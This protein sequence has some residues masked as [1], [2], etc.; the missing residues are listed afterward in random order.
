MFEGPE[1]KFQ[2]HVANYFLKK[3]HFALLEDADIQIVLTTLSKII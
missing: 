1:K 2:R 3:H